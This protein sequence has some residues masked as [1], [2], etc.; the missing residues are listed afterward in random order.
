MRG[1]MIWR[2]GFAHHTRL[3]MLVL[4]FTAAFPTL[5]PGSHPINAASPDIDLQVLGD[6]AILW[7]INNIAPG[8]SGS[9]AL[10]LRGNGV[11][12]G[13]VTIWITDIMDYASNN[14]E[15][16]TDNGS[17][18]DLS[19]YLQLQ[20]VASRL[21]TNLVMPAN[22]WQFPQQ[23][24]S[25]T[26]I[27]I[28]LPPTDN[29]AQIVWKWQVP[30]ET[31][32]AV[33]GERVVFVIHYALEEMGV[34]AP[35]SGGGG[36]GSPVTLSPTALPVTVAVSGSDEPGKSLKL[37]NDGTVVESATVT[38]SGGGL[39]LGF[40]QGTQITTESGRIPQQLDI[41]MATEIPPLPQ[42]TVLISPIYDVVALFGDEA[43]KVTSAE[44]VRFSPPLRLVLQVPAG[45]FPKDATLQVMYYDE[46]LGWTELE[47]EGVFV[48]GQTEIT[49]LVYHFTR[50]AV[51]ARLPSTPSVLP[52]TDAT[53]TLQLPASANFQVNNLEIAPNRTEPG[54]SIAIRLQVTNTGGVSGE[55]SLTLKINDFF[56]DAKVLALAAG[57][58]QSLSFTVTA[59]K[60]GTYQ[61]TVGPSQNGIDM[62]AVSAIFEVTASGNP[63]IRTTIFVISSSVII[64]AIILL[65][66]RYWKRRNYMTDL[67]RRP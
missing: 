37:R 63:W 50:F 51:V 61:V 54:D 39:A 2:F 62:N 44:A 34:S 48:S 38:A 42:G 59:N 66:R 47:N 9:T 18:P 33:Q 3:A 12:N 17:E 64:I 52:T 15:T 19:Q 13:L 10:T 6:R 8:Q 35:S 30:A 26:R 27:T 65:V 36:G 14:P 29:A 56:V 53:P 25:A 5:M 40:A 49:A 67:F 4:S 20:L 31:P 46:Q 1:M 21:A 55:R 28:S 58:T 16:N 24:N 57:Q 32:N 41:K 11:Q 45:A 7:E 43:Q 22:P 60:P 23:S